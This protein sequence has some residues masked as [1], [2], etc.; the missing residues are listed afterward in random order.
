[1]QT[2]TG[3]SVKPIQ[4][5]FVG[6]ASDPGILN[7]GTRQPYDKKILRSTRPGQF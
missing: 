3:G 6:K 2:Y 4:N 5:I 7:G 1:M